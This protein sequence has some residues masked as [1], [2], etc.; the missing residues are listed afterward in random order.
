MQSQPRGSVQYPCPGLPASYSIILTLLLLVYIDGGTR[1]YYRVL[2]SGRILPHI[3]RVFNIIWTSTETAAQS[4]HH[5]YRGG[6]YPA[7][8]LTTS[9]PFH[10]PQPPFYSP[11]TT[12]GL[13]GLTEHY[14]FPYT[15]PLL[16]WLPVTASVSLLLSLVSTLTSSPYTV[17]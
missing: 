3:H 13:Y 6:I 4:W 5:S 15:L 17:T 2:P 8:Y 10:N 11:V 9:G 1:G 7:R 14:Y 12:T 16:P